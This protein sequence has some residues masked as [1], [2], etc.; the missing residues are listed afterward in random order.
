MT[1]GAVDPPLG[2][3]RLHVAKL[4]SALVAT[5]NPDINSKLSE[6]GTIGVLLVSILFYYFIFLVYILFAFFIFVIS[7]N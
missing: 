4:L 5:H 2:N 6:L 7:K 1:S 3:T